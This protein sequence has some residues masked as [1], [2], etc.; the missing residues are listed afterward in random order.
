MLSKIYKSK[1]TRNRDLVFILAMSMLPIILL[2]YTLVLSGKWESALNAWQGEYKSHGIITNPW[3]HFL[4]PFCL[5]IC[6]FVFSSWLGFITRSR[7]QLGTLNDRTRLFISLS[8]I[9]FGSIGFYLSVLQASMIHLWFEDIILGSSLFPR[10]T[11]GLSLF[12]LFINMY[13]IVKN[14]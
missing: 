11:I 3:Q 10:L 12:V 2:V 9:A 8:L 4:L 6:I 13:R 5:T 7:A 1:P 14:S